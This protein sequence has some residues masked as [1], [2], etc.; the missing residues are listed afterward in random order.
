[1]DM[2]TIKELM[3]HLP[4]TMAGMVS[5]R[6]DALPKGINPT[7]MIEAVVI[8]LL[9]AGAVGVGGYLV[10]WPVM[11]AE[12]QQ[13]RSDIREIKDDIRLDKSEITQLRVDSARQ[14]SAIDGLR[15]CG[16]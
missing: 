1:M 8:A 10:A 2:P 15:K 9:T 5:G 11:K 16:R 7:R 3:E 14:G 12:I 6:V 13:I 4:F